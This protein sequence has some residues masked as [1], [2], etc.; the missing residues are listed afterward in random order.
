MME[1]SVIDQLFLE[2]SQVTNARTAA[3]AALA[4]EVTRL[5]RI[6]QT[7]IW[8]CERNSM[9]VQA[10]TFRVVCEVCEVFE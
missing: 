3:E 1:T 6:L 5:R 2:L 9:T 10:G 7:V 4:Q 8:D